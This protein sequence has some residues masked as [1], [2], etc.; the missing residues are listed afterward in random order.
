MRHISALAEVALHKALHVRCS[1][2]AGVAA[3]DLQIDGREVVVGV[4]VKLSLEVRQR[5]RL[6]HGARGVRIAK[7]GGDAVD[8]RVHRCERTQYVVKGPVFQHQ[9]N[10]MPQLIQS[11]GHDFSGG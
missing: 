2:R 10:N 7:P 4:G 5:L 9:D 6:D 3:K 8:P 11:K 1:T